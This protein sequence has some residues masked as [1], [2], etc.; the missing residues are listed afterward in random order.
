MDIKVSV[1][2]SIQAAI[3]A[4]TN[5]GGGRVVIQSGEHSSDT[6]YLKSNVELHVGRGAVIQGSSKPEDYDDF[7]DPG[8][9]DV[10]P[11]GSRKCLI[12]AA[13][14]T[15]I[16][17]TGDGEINGAGPDFYDTTAEGRFF[18]KPPHPRPRMVQFFN[19]KNVLIEGTSFI[20][21]PGWTFWLI[22]CEDVAI[23]RIKITGCQRMINN[24][25][26]DIDGC[27][28]VTVSDCL[29]RTGDD[30][31]VLRAIRKG[32]DRT[33]CCE[34]VT[35]TNCVLDSWC[36]GIR[37]GCPSDDTIRNCTFSNIV[38]QGEGRGII[39]NN[40]KRYLR[41][42]CTGY[43]DV[44]NL[45]FSNIVIDTKRVPIGIN[46]EEGITLRHLGGVTFSN[47]RI[48]SDQP[49]KLEG[50]AE[51]IIEDVRFSQ[52]KLNKAMEIHHAREVALDSVTITD[53]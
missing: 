47:C 16:A 23:R 52:V 6:I 42:G 45:V 37:V 26:I 49:C 38:I 33:A 15:N 5:N 32:P 48:R 13:N 7:S 40:P 44:N 14:A 51:T 3:D 50:A 41:P 39:F 46:V 2:E 25:G 34:D 21:S 9:E 35:V 20:D 43:M 4:A 11:E 10:S 36:Q 18:A 17:I 8:F 28:R 27:R 30:S 31:L 19:C 1:G 12:A 22:S 53:V 29:I 24:D